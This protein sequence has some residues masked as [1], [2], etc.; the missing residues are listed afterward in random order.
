MVTKRIPTILI[1]VL[2]A[3]ILIIAGCTP[4][5]STTSYTITATAGAGGS[6]SPSGA[7]MVSEGSNQTFII[8]PAEGYE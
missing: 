1:V 2:I 8:T 5:T 6:I 7:L 3:I 4:P